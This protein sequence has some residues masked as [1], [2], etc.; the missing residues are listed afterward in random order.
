MADLAVVGPMARTVD[1]LRAG[2]NAM[3]GPDRWNTPA[4][5]LSLPPS[6]G[7]QLSDFR[8]AAWID[9]DFCPVDAATRTAIESLAGQLRHGGAAVDEEARP[10]FTLEKAAS[11][12][13]RLLSAALAGGYSLSELEV[14]A[15]DATATPAGLAGRAAAMRHREWLSENE[16]RMQIRRK[17]EAFFE[18]FDVIL[19]PV[20]PRA[21]IAHDHSPVAAERVVDVDGVERSYLE[22]FHWIAPAGLAYLPSTV[23]PIGFDTDGLPI[24]VQVVGPYLH[25]MTTLRV[26][27]LI[28][29][30]FD[31][32]PTPP[33][34]SV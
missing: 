23:A 19:M 27:E 17:F 33:A 18:D 32:C 22:L 16:R 24:G 6:R 28:A 9:D 26:A 30:I 25:D 3:S 8:I 5:S 31:G 4:W 7:Q 20:Q 10:A 1:D 21:A 13:R 29:E 34:A 11:V 15:A 2:L 14:M 12:F